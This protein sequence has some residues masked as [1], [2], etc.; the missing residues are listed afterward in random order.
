MFI[1]EALL[2][3][4]F[5]KEGSVKDLIKVS[6]REQCSFSAQQFEEREN[7]VQCREA[8]EWMRKIQ[9]EIGEKKIYILYIIQDWK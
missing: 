6:G 8:D 1:K 5:C 7:C 9:P 2:K 3:K 4:F